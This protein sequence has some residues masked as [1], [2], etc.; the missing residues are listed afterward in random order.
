LETYIYRNNT[1]FC[2]ELLPTTKCNLACTGCIARTQSS[3]SNNLYSLGSMNDM[4]EEMMFYCV[5]QGID[6]IIEKLISSQ[7]VGYELSFDVFV[8]GGEPFININNLL[9]ALLRG[10]SL[11]YDTC[12]KM[13]YVLC[14]TEIYILV[15]IL[16]MKNINMGT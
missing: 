4:S 11:F 13:N 12:N 1:S 6:Q 9:G 7:I 5:E 8:T 3:S 10:R 14:Q 16:L 2:L 15:I